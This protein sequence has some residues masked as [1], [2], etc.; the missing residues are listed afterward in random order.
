MR[1]MHNVIAVVAAS[2][3]SAICLA[4]AASVVVHPAGPTVP[5]NLLRMEL[6]FEHPQP[7]PFD[8]DRLKLLDARGLE[9]RHALLDVALPSPDGRR[10]TVLMDPGRVKMGVGPN[11]EAGRALDAGSTVTL[12]LA[13]ATP[14]E[15]TV[16]KT[17]RVTAGLTRPLQP[18][19]W[20]LTPPRRA[21][22]DALVVALQA[23]ISAVGEGLLAVVDARGRRVQG[24]ASLG[25]GDAVWRFIPY[26]PWAPGPYRLVTHPELE[27]PAGNR[28]CAAFEARVRTAARCEGM[29]LP[30]KPKPAS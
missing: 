28:Q 7:L 14:A 3:L 27:D 26:R 9:L 10:I 20:T 17:W 25:G 30:F 24:S 29:S 19:S 12:H 2:A 21:S 5:E 11:R 23:P 8:M 4:E 13:G 6:R 15:E 22:R 16:I 1:P 18:G